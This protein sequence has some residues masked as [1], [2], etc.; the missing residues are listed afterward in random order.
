MS[1]D[2]KHAAAQRGARSKGLSQTSILTFLS[3]SIL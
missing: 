3:T 2:K 1:P